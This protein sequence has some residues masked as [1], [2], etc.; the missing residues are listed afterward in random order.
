MSVPYQE[1][2]GLILPEKLH[3]FKVFANHVV[4]MVELEAEDM[5]VVAGQLSCIH[6]SNVTLTSHTVKSHAR[7][8]SGALVH[9]SKIA[10]SNPTPTTGSSS[11]GGDESQSQYLV[12]LLSDL[13]FSADILYEEATRLVR[14]VRETRDILR[15]CYV[16]AD[17]FYKLGLPSYDDFLVQQGQISATRPGRNSNRPQQHN[18]STVKTAWDKFIGGDGRKLSD[19]AEMLVMA[20]FSTSPY[21]QILQVRP[22]EA[23]NMVMKLE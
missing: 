8:L 14:I 21:Q 22:V 9:F 1:F 6:I 23:E 20:D 11:A 17:I 18:A 10:K 3:W 16:Y 7:E 13:W 4:D 19:L 15:T 2:G 12:R 5:H